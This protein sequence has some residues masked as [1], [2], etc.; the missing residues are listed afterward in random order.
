MAF[1]IAL[2]L[3]AG[4]TAIAFHGFEIY[5]DYTHTQHEAQEELRDRAVLLAQ[6]AETR[7]ETI[8]QIVAAAVFRLSRP[9]AMTETQSELFERGVAFAPDLFAL[10]H[11]DRQGRYQ[12]GYS[13]DGQ[14]RND[15]SDCRFFRV[16]RAEGRD[17]F[18][19]L[20]FDDE[21]G[22][23]PRLGI[24][25][26]IVDSQG[27]M[28]GAV[29]GIVD[30]E[31]FRHRL[32]ERMGEKIDRAALFDRAGI[33]LVTWQRNDSRPGPDL[34]S[35]T[36]RRLAPLGPETGSLRLDP[37]EGAF[38]S[39][40]PYPLWI[41]TALDRDRFFA[42]WRSKAQTN[43]ILLVG[44][45]AVLA[46]LAGLGARQIRVRRRAEQAMRDA[47]AAQDAAIN[48]VNAKLR[49]ETAKRILVDT[50]FK[51][52]ELRFHHF[53]DNLPIGAYIKHPDG[54]YL[55]ANKRFSEVC[56]LGDQPVRDRTV[57]DLFSESLAMT[58]TAIDR[59]VLS[60]RK[61]I[62]RNVAFRQGER[63]RHFIA[64]KFP[65]PLADG[66]LVIGGASIDTTEQQQA[67]QA[68]HQAQKMEAMGHL[69][70]GIAHDFNNLLTIILGNME[71]LIDELGEMP[72]LAHHANEAR[73][74]AKR[75]RALTQRLLGMFRRHTGS[76]DDQ[77]E[78][79]SL[80]ASMS[81]LLRRTL[82][83]AIE[84]RISVLPRAILVPMEAGLLESVLINLAINARDAMPEGGRLDIAV[85][86]PP[87]STAT[88][89]DPAPP[90]LITVADT[91]QGMDPAVARRAFDPFFTTK[92]GERGSGLGLTMVHSAVTQAGG[93]V[94]LES[95]LGKG[96]V[97]TLKL[98]RLEGRSVASD[99]GLGDAEA[100]L[101]GRGERILVVEDE[102]EVR[103]VAMHM[104]A[105][106]GYQVESVDTGVEA[107]NRLRT[108]EPAIDLVF[109]DIVMPGGLDGLALADAIAKDWPG[110]PVLLASG[111]SDRLDR[112]VGERPPVLA[113]PYDRS[114]LARQVR[115]RL[116]QVRLTAKM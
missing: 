79:N 61:A 110:L 82:G 10:A 115:E 59:E 106:L 41:G 13:R 71:M 9:A 60:Q 2:A 44:V 84:V 78:V 38:A 50:A 86:E 93:D 99:Y 21:S 92:S 98:P 68:L 74:A 28:V 56:E 52:S 26:R 81:D 73:L 75:G 55:Y 89:S 4:L 109:S 45:L 12:G 42:S 97:I 107:L 88:A 29:V 49:E 51:E 33:A 95:D 62:S 11:Y 63:T 48:A 67:L 77:C 64:C 116:D 57:Y 102:P 113:K 15:C 32:I 46:G 94:I 54:R 85:R 111:H 18:L 87:A 23:D 35:Q 96:T 83:D 17:H 112:M 72:D 30:A 14:H 76:P 101:A 34:L 80:V 22:R 36:A 37:A 70:G 24:S 25:R 20:A 7:L 16:H 47:V 3:F 103:R 40:A 91:G 69:T 114:T 19:G 105:R 39:L 90:V 53:M 1:L 5:E 31:R 100:R 58:A 8:D 108:A 43:V 66:S 6:Q 104:L 65:I 27:Q